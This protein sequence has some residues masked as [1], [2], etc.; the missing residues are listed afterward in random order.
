MAG[1]ITHTWNGSVL[2]ITSDSGT[3][4]AN[5]IGPTGPRG[6]QGEPGVVYN[7]AGVLISGGSSSDPDLTGYATEDYVDNA[8]A[9]VEAKI[10][11][12]SSFATKTYVN[13][14][15]STVEAKI[16]NTS[17]FATKTYV[18]TALNGYA[19]ETYVGEA[20]AQAQLGGEGSD[21]D[22]SLYATKEYVNDAIAGVSG[23][24]LT[25]YYTKTEVDTAISNAL[26]AIGVA[27][28]GAY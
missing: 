11:D 2:T 15:V 18:S 4:S 9:E 12:T 24:D 13:S 23:A 5:L 7:T 20:I 19:T 8:I 26:A 6:P 28:E 17:N 3:S 27:E 25:N 21:I 10:P 14:A 16:P 22:L 1:T